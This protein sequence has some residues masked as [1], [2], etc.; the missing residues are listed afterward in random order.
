MN[1]ILHS[2]TENPLFV[3]RGFLNA[4]D[5]Y[6]FTLEEL[7]ET[8]GAQ[9]T[10]Y[11]QMHPNQQLLFMGIKARIK[12]LLGLSCG[13]QISEPTIY[14]LPPG[15]GHINFPLTSASLV[16]IDL[17]DGCL[18]ITK[19]PHGLTFEDLSERN[20]SHFLVFSLSQ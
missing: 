3:F 4:S 9:G 19:D 1:L 13:C 7:N 8:I 17:L 20:W 18:R 12:E 14:H 6:A 2:L 11:A 15:T 16:V 10:P 5:R